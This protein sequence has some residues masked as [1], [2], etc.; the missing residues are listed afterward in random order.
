[1]WIALASAALAACGGSDSTECRGSEC[2]SDAAV[3]DA[4]VPQDGDVDADAARPGDG[5]TADAGVD[6]GYS[7]C[8]TA[9]DCPVPE[10]LHECIHCQDGS[11]R[12][13]QVACVDRLCALQWPES[14]PELEDLVACTSDVDCARR[15]CL[16]KCQGDGRDACLPAACTD[17]LCAIAASTCGLHLEPCP[18]GTRADVQ[19]GA[20]GISGGCS[21]QVYG[22]FQACETDADCPSGEP[23]SD[24]TCEIVSG[25]L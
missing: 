16:I 1:M 3:D 12:C 23:C 17:G 5:S 9:A 22:C 14:C 6:A 13:N 19:C 10:G 24:G 2:E 25:C 21:F 20:C 7:E 15:E 18:R 11:E 4:R 8:M